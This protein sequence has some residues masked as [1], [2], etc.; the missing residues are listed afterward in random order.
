M[1]TKR[2]AWFALVWVAPIALSLVGCPSEKCTSASWCEEHYRDDPECP[3]PRFS[4]TN[5]ACDFDCGCGPSDKK[6]VCAPGI[7]MHY[8]GSWQCRDEP[9]D[10]KS[11]SKCSDVPP[12]GY[13]GEG[14]WSCENGSCE[15]PG[16]DF[17]E[18]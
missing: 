16:A 3:H 15:F 4:C 8:E 7:C 9:P 14:S 6:D 10:C 17:S 12:L 18:E 13:G 1:I 5:G 2:R 11:A